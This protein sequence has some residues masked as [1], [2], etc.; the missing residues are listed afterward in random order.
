MEIIYTKDPKMLSKWD[1]FVFNEDR[2]SHLLLSDWVSSYHSYGF[3]TDFCLAID[4]GKIVGGFAAVVAKAMFFRFYI[5]PYGPV[6]SAGYESALEAL[7]AAVPKRAKLFKAAYCHITLPACGAARNKHIYDN[8]PSLAALQNAREGHLFR[9]VYSSNGLNW[10][11]LQGFDVESK[12]MTLK[13]A[14]RRNI[15]NSYRKDLTFA[16]LDSN[17]KLEQ[18]YRLF[19]ENA[20]A[21]GYSIRSWHEIRESLFA[22]LEKNALKML[23]VY[24]N[25]E[26]KGAILLV[27]AGNYYTYILGGSK[28]EVPDLRTG[29][30]LQWEAV[31][32]SLDEG[33]DGYNIS[34]GGS[35]GVVEFKNSFGTDQLLFEQSKYH[36]VLRPALFKSY[37]F[38]E[39][40]MKPY[41]KQIARLLAKFKR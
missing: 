36:W 10:V 26:I 28:K 13:P 1:A 8:L 18:G 21:A 24:K 35:K 4:Q 40:R 9:Y 7:V 12:I 14:V 23:A 3:D 17:E 29:D 31:K 19:L 37:L 6:V 39:D 25:N 20:D 38:L 33:L 22:L 15:R 16:I 11:D 34:L 5:V 30:F 41:K 32:L 27:K 2:A